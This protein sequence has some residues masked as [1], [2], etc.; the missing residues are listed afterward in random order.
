MDRLLEKYCKMVDRWLDQ[1]IQKE[2]LTS[3][4]LFGTVYAFRGFMHILK[5]KERFDVIQKKEEPGVQS[6]EQLEKRIARIEEQLKNG[7]ILVF[8]G[9]ADIED[10]VDVVEARLEV[11][12]ISCRRNLKT[13]E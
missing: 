9:V 13:E 10:I 11:R 4:D 2:E 3:D 12:D 1:L 8:K 5:L 7:K 6:I